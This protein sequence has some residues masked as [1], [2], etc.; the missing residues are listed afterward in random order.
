MCRETLSRLVWRRFSRRGLSGARFGQ[1]PSNPAIRGCPLMSCC[2]V[3]LMSRWR[4]ITES[5]SEGCPHVRDEPVGVESLSLH[6]QDI[7][8]L[9]GAII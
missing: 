4:I 6:V 8:D 9:T 2:S 3:T 7:P 1:M 5:S